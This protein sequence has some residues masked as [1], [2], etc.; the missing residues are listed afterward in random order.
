MVVTSRICKKAT[1][2]TFLLMSTM[3]TSFIDF[4]YRIQF[5]MGRMKKTKMVAK[6][7]STCSEPIVEFYRQ[8]ELNYPSR[9]RR[10]E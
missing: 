7:Y 3:F 8:G 6:P 9:I 5:R 10:A 2:K 1:K 4:L